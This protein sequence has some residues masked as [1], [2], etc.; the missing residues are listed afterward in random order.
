MGTGRASERVGRKEGGID[1]GQVDSHKEKSGISRLAGVAMVTELG[2]D[3]IMPWLIQ[4]W[5][6]PI[7]PPLETEREGGRGREGGCD[8]TMQ[9]EERMLREGGGHGKV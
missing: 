8:G 7:T 6:A 5:Q 9:K 1:T 2:R 4:T 3:V